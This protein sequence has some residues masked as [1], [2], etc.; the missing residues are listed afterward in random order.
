MMVFFLYPPP[1][2]KA[3]AWTG[4]VLG[5]AGETTGTKGPRPTGMSGHYISAELC[6]QSSASAR[7]LQTGAPV[8]ATNQPRLLCGTLTLFAT[9]FPYSLPLFTPPSA[10]SRSLDGT[11]NVLGV[12]RRT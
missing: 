1:P 11:G 12:A 3:G 4:N 10:E 2:L 6:S 5:V 7:M 9:K 8:E